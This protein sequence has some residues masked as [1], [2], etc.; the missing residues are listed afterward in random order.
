M[1]VALA[2]TGPAREAIEAAL[3]DVDV[4]V[5]DAEPEGIGDADVAVVVDAAGG[6]SF[7]RANSTALEAQTPWIAVE[8][9]GLGGEVK[10]DIEVGVT[11]F[12]PEETACYDCLT[13]RVRA[14][15][16]DRTPDGESQDAHEVCGERSTHLSRFAGALVGR[17][18]VELL[19]GTPSTLLGGVVHIPGRLDPQH[20]PAVPTCSCQQP[21]PLFQLNFKEEKDVSETLAAG[22]RAVDARIG[23]ITRAAEFGPCPVTHC[24]GTLANTGEFSPPH[25]PVE[26][27][28]GARDRETATARA[29]WQALGQYC[30]SIVRGADV[31]RAAGA[32]LELAV[33]PADFVT[34]TTVEGEDPLTWVLARKLDDG[35]HGHVPADRVYVPS[36][37]G[38]L[39]PAVA[40]GLG[41]RSATASAMLVALYE[42]VEHDATM[43]SWYSTH[44][45]PELTVSDE[46]FQHLCRRAGAEGLTVTPLLVTQ[47][48]DIPVVTVAV[49]SDE[50]PRFAVGSAAHMQAD[51]AALAALE[52]ALGY[53]TWLDA[54][55]RDEAQSQ[56]PDLTRYADFPVEIRSFVEVDESVEATDVSHSTSGALEQYL[57]AIQRIQEAGISPY[58]VRLT[59]PDVAT[60]GFEVGRAV[61]PGAQPRFGADSCFGKR[62]RSVPEAS[63]DAPRLDRFH[64][65]YPDPW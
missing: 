51:R 40:G 46:Q 8:T 24:R 38:R 34:D 61:V 59:T 47:D 49:H 57:G 44:E 15:G 45:P 16:G 10:N 6:G 12:A 64:H 31:V 35:R 29:L 58:G 30:G 43:L 52:E 62:A 53:W 23:I 20:L 1:E 42:T 14:T 33:D 7:E 22:R 50:W 21:L 32:D 54:V 26:A 17:E 36:P 27:R 28:G 25:A 9:G 41:V 18:L 60:L 63:G 48:I 11:G 55:G 56:A 37:D 39:T 2:G 4:E 19:S 65:P 3:T 5:H 13:S